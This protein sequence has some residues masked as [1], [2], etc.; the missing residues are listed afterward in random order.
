M[1]FPSEL[2]KLREIGKLKKIQKVSLPYIFVH[3]IKY[4][5]GSHLIHVT[6]YKKEKKK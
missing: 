3:L 1:R 4:L 2:R 5:V 6:K